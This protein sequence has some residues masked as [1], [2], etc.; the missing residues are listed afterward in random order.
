MGPDETRRILRQASIAV[1]DWIHCEK[2]VLDTPPDASTYNYW[3]KEA[4][5]AR[6]KMNEAINAALAA[7]CPKEPVD[8]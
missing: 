8:G 4:I 2:L 6:G 3:R 1:E 7:T 5:K